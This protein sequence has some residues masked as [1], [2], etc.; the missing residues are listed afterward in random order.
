M[1]CDSTSRPKVGRYSE[2]VLVNVRYYTTVSVQ[3]WQP[4]RAILQCGSKK[5]PLKKHLTRSSVVGKSGL[6]ALQSLCK[7]LQDG[8]YT[9]LL[10]G[11][12][13]N[14]PNFRASYELPRCLLRMDFSFI[15]IL[16]SILLVWAL[17]QKFPVA[18]TSLKAEC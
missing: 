7:T 15:K 3:V 18:V 14:L 16:V 11:S 9:C 1:V 2:A 17:F 6:V 5:E 12:Q 13:L 4:D 8:P 10:C